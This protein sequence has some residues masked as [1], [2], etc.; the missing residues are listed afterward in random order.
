M[1]AGLWEGNHL[2]LNVLLPIVGLCTL[3]VSVTTRKDAE[4]GINWSSG[5]MLTLA[6]LA[7]AFTSRS[8]DVWSP[9]LFALGVAATIAGT[10]WQLARR[11]GAQ[12]ART[13]TRA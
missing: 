7:F 11:D 6:M 3:A 2:D 1:R 4:R 9:C 10:G 8:L 5:A 12:L 13:A